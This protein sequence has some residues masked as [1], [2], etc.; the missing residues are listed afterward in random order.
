[1]AGGRRGFRRR[2]DGRHRAIRRVGKGKAPSNGPGVGRRWI[3]KAAPEGRKRSRFEGRRG[4]QPD[5]APGRGGAPETEGSGIGV[6]GVRG[7]RMR[8]FWL[9]RG[10]FYARANYLP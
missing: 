1:M 3:E 4:R 8:F 7:G 2:P 10:F 6:G 5:S 9:F